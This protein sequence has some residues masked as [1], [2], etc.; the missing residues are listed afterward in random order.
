[1]SDFHNLLKKVE[2]LCMGDQYV[3]KKLIRYFIMDRKLR[4]I[5]QLLTNLQN[6]PSMSNILIARY[7]AYNN[8]TLQLNQYS[9]T[10]ALSTLKTPQNNPVQ[11]RPPSNG[12]SYFQKYD[13]FCPNTSSNILKEHN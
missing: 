9:R 2:K 12:N 6:L 5:I 8:S 3:W 13:K 10:Q 1:M 11:P 7:R 4:S